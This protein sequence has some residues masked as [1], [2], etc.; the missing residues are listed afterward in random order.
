M[1]VL[2]PTQL[3]AK[4]LLGI[5]D[6]DKQLINNVFLV[7]SGSLKIIFHLSFPFKLIQGILPTQD[8]LPKPNFVNVVTIKYLDKN[9]NCKCSV[10]ISS[11][12]NAHVSIIVRKARGLIRGL[13]GLVQCACCLNLLDSKASRCLYS[14]NY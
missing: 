9:S 11:H 3:L 14:M 10:T 1:N 6:R 4:V 7:I 13:N 2:T 12:A 8:I 5:Y